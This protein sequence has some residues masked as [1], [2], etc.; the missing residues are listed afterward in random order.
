MVFIILVFTLF[1]SCY[2]DIIDLD[3][4]DFDPQIVIEGSITDQPGPYLIR[5]SKTGY[6]NQLNNFPTVSGAE[7]MIHDN[8]GYSE[9][10]IE[11]EA[12]L[13]ETHT[14]RGVSG[15]TYTLQV[16]AEGKEFFATSRMPEPLSMDYISFQN[17]G[18]EYTLICAFTDRKGREDFCRIKVYKNG[19]LANRYL[20]QGKY[21]DGEQI[22]ID[23]FD[24]EFYPN[25][26]VRVEFFTISKET[27]IYLSM[28]NPQEGGGDYNPEYPEYMAVSLANPKSNLSNNALGYFS[29]QSVKDYTRVVR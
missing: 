26:Q 19:E 3:L 25:D 27:F 16:L 23:D 21:R 17:H 24:V 10:L 2:R 20:Y 12:G 4:Q 5:I 13:Y 15:R 18:G 7:V 8:S 9:T 29:A 28:L 11:T 1:F 22:I 6:L 14:M